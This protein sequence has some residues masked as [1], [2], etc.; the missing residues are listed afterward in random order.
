M[1]AWSLIGLAIGAGAGLVNGVLVAYGRL[2]P[3]LVTLATLSIYD[4]LAIK[5][6]PEPGGAIPLVLHEA[7]SPNPLAP[8][9]LV[10]VGVVIA[11]WLVFRRTSFGVNVYALGNDEEAAR[12]RGVPIRRTKVGAYVFCGDVRGGGGLFFVATTTAGDA[13]S[14]D[15]FILTSIAAVVLGGISFFGGRGSAIGADRRRLRPHGGRERPL[16]RAHQP[17][18]PGRVPGPVPRRRGRPRRPRR[19]ARGRGDMSAQLET[20]SRRLRELPAFLTPDRRRV[21]FAF[22]AVVL[23]FGV[24]DVLHPGFA[25]AASVKAILL[26]ASFVG[27][28]AAG[29]TF[30]VLDRRHRPLGAVGAERRGD[31]ARDDVARPRL[32]DLVGPAADARDGPRRRDVQR[33]RRRLP[34]RARGRDHAGDER[35]R[36][37]A[38]ARALQGPHLL[39]VRVLH[40]E[41]RHRQPSRRGILGVPERALP[42][43]RRRPAD[44]VPALVHDVRPARL[45][46]RQQPA[47]ELP[48][49]RQRAPRHGR[50]LHAERA[51]RRVRGH[52]ARRLRRPGLAR[53][54]RSRTSSSR[55]PRS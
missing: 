30:V 36:A 32:A 2:Q 42:L 28:V 11:I 41:G 17:A 39:V 44:H 3:I 52:H 14:G 16:L 26:T 7:C 23:V 38:H 27:F 15:S 13:T 12:A 5:V 4:G 40:A 53:D 6:L 20:R 47:G 45:R 35:R 55:S 1:L 31:P 8:W 10:F 24:G 51:L 54:G 9:G 50:A 33:P 34:R 19:P 48:R 18:L 46:D 21:V 25:S 43:A 37:G 29:Q 49:R 22:G